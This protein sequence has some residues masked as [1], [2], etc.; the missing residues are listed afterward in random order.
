MPFNDFYV[1]DF[2]MVFHEKAKS[3][4]KKRELRIID[5]ESQAVME[6]KNQLNEK[7]LIVHKP[8]LPFLGEPCRF[9]AV[10]WFYSSVSPAF[11]MPNAVLALSLLESL[12]IILRRSL[13]IQ[14]FPFEYFYHMKV[15]AQYLFRVFYVLHSFW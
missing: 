6:S 15:S 10:Q 11:A 5:R 1:D 9:T 3:T 13:W 7:C 2:G 4:G 8:R 12:F 14:L